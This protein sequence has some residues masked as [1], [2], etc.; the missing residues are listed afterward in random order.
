MPADFSVIQAVVFDIGGTLFNSAAPESR[1]TFRAGLALAHEYL[2]RQSPDPPPIAAYQRALQIHLLRAYLWSRL[3]R[4]EMDSMKELRRAHRRFGI[5]LADDD[6]LEIAKRIH[7]PAMACAHASPGTVEAVR[8]LRDRGFKLAIISNTIAP[9]PGLDAHLAVE[10]LLDFFPVR[11][12]SCVVGV[13]KPNPR[14]F[15]EALAALDVAPERAVYIGDRTT[16]DVR[17]ARRVGMM[18]VLRA[19]QTT[20]RRRWF[21][22]DAVIREI[23]ELTDLLPA[24]APAPA[25]ALPPVPQ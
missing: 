18:S 4:C 16:I 6:L 25:P 2:R 23:A 22:P 13:P 8:I 9:P 10:G 11:K 24:P 1:A 12:Y 15:R 20:A 7:K 14:I 5:E 17:G 3:T 19:P 21:S